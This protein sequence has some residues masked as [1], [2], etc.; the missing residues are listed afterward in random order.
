MTIIKNNIIYDQNH[1]LATD[2]YFPNDTTTNTKILIFWHGGGWFRG[3]KE[4]VKEFGISFA[5]AGFMTFI[6]EYRLAPK[7]IYPA[8]HN[9]A[10]TFVN[11]LLESH[12]TDDDDQKN[13]FQIGASVGGNMAIYLAGKFGFPTVTWSAPVEFSD[14]FKNHIDTKPSPVAKEEF[15]LTDRHQIAA[16]FYKYF[17]QTYAGTANEAVLAKINAKSFD[18]IN[19]GPLLMINSADELTPITSVLDF[20]NYLS[21]KDLPS[22]LMVIPGHGH[23][24]DYAKEY[25]DESLDYLFQ[26][27]KRRR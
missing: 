3:N 20:I 2:I 25:L 22:Q 10:L 4:S 17:A 6:P 12:Y 14:W 9:D 16:S 1:Q 7:H 24:M 26:I 21:T 13:I 27:A 15:G 23:A 8:A 5:N 11:W 18:L 19:L